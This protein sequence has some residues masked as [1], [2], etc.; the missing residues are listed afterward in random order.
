MV[1]LV[2]LVCIRYTGHNKSRKNTIAET[3]D[4]TDLK[5]RCVTVFLCQETVEF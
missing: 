4:C 2:S 3:T 5:K 1:K